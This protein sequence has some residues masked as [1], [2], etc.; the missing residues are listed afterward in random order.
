MGLI[1][2]L[3]TV[4]ERWIFGEPEDVNGMLDKQCCEVNII[5]TYGLKLQYLR[6]FRAKYPPP[7]HPPPNCW[8]NDNSKT[9]F[10]NHVF[11]LH[12]LLL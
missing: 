12:F 1:Q 11:N 5:V 6:Q 3:L 7:P 10:L 4:L 9:G 2:E 8:R